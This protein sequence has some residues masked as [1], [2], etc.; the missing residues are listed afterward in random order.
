MGNHVSVQWALA[1]SEDNPGKPLSMSL[2]WL[3]CVDDELSALA[4]KIS[5]SI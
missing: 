3:E 2:W 1:K 4:V 5:F